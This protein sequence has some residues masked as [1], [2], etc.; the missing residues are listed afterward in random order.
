MNIPCQEY[1]KKFIIFGPF[2]VA[3]IHEYSWFI[4]GFLGIFMNIISEY[5][6]IYQEYSLIFMNIHAENKRGLRAESKVS[7]ETFSWLNFT[8][9]IKIWPFDFIFGP[10]APIFWV[11][12]E[13]LPIATYHQNFEEFQSKLEIARYISHLSTCFCACAQKQRIPI[14][15]WLCILKLYL[16]GHVTLK[17]MWRKNRKFQ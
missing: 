4:L 3:D 12:V 14:V 11:T 9:F 1:S 15:I 5:S 16:Q 6:W 7:T 17:V 2:N 13:D 10:T 8:F